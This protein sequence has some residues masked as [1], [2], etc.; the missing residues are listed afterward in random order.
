MAKVEKTSIGLTTDLLKRLDRVA[1]ATGQSRSEVIREMVETGLDQA[2]MMVKVTTD[3]VLMAAVG[4][5]MADPAVLRQMIHGLRS[6][7]NDQQLD[8]FQQRV[9]AIGVHSSE[10]LKK[11]RK[12]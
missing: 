4:K 6:E 9:E 5:V 10:T 2:E 11:K 12:V 8:L 7:L 3:P 1:R